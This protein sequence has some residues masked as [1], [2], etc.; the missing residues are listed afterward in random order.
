MAKRIVFVLLAILVLFVS[1]SEDMFGT[2]EPTDISLDKNLMEY[3][4]IS[5]V[6]GKNLQLIASVTTKDGNTTSDN[7][8]WMDMPTDTS[9]FKVVSTSKGILTFQ[10]YKS[11]TYVVTA[12]VKYRGQVTKTAQ[13]VI[14]IKD[15]LVCLD[16][17]ERNSSAFDSKTLYVGN[18]LSLAVD[19]TPSETSQTDVVW[20]VDNGDILTITEQDGG[21]AIASAKKAGTAVITAKSKDNS[22]IS[23]KVTIIV[24]ESGE[25]QKMPVRSVSLEMDGNEI[26][27]AKSAIINATVLDGNS[28][29]MST[30]KVE[31]SLTGEDATIAS[32]Q[33][34]SARSVKV[35]ANKGGNITVHAEYTND[36]T[37]VTADYPITI[38]GDISAIGVSS[39]YYNIAVNEEQEINVQYNSDIV[40]SRKGFTCNYDSNFINVV[41]SDKSSKMVIQA[42][43]EG[44]SKITLVSKC[45]SSL[46]AEI[47]V[48]AKTAVTEADRIHKVTLSA[49]QLNYYPVSGGFTEGTLSAYVYRRGD[50]GTNSVDST[51]NV[52]WSISDPS[53]AILTEGANNSVSVRPVK[54]GK[55]VITAKSADNEKVSASANITVNG[56]LVSLIAQTSTVNMSGEEEIDIPLIAYPEYAVYSAPKAQCSND[57]VSAS[58][59]KTDDVYSL[60]IKAKSLSGVTSVDVY[61]NGKVMETVMVNVHISEPVTIRTV[62]LSSSSFSLK[63]DSDPVYVEA[64]ALDKDGNEIETE[65][66][67]KGD[68]NAKSVSKIERVGTNGFYIYP[69]NAGYADW[70]FYS[71]SAKTEARLHL[72]V[73]GG[74]VTETIRLKAETDSVSIVKGNSYEVELNVLPFGA[75]LKENIIWT[76]E[77]QAVADVKGNGLNATVYAIGKGSTIIH[78]E[79]DVSGLTANITVN[80]VEKAQVEDTNI[81]YVEIAGSGSKTHLV[82][83]ALNKAITLNA[84]AYKAD[85]TKITAE[86]FIWTLSGSSATELNTSGSSYTVRTSDFGGYDNPA[87]ITATSVSNPNAKATFKVYVI[88]GST[89]VPETAPK[90][91]ISCA[92]ITLEVN[93]TKSV[94]YVVLPATYSENLTVQISNDNIEASV[95]QNAR[96]ITVK[97]LK[98]GLATVT[99]TNGEK[100]VAFNVNVVEK[101]EKIDTNISSLTL[102]R[103]YLSYDL[104]SKAPQTISATV[105]KNGIACDEKVIWTLSSPDMVS[106]TENGNSVLVMPSDKV[107]TVTI[108]AS[109]ASNPSVKASCLV[110]II[111]STTIKQALRYVMLS[112]SVVEL[113]KGQSVSLTAS[114]QPASVFAEADVTWSTSN[115]SIATVKDGEVKAVSAGQAVITVSAEG[116]T[117]GCLVIVKED[118]VVPETPKSITLS[119]SVLLLSQED[120]DKTFSITA[121]VQSSAGGTITD[122]SVIWS[123]EDPNG[124]VEYNTSYNTITLVPMSAG[125]ATITAKMDDIE[126]QA[127]VIVGEAYVD[128]SLSDIILSYDTLVLETGKTSDVRATTV[129]A[130]SEDNLVWE[131]SNTNVSITQKDN[132]NVVLKG[133][134]EGETILTVYSIENPSVKT[135]MNITVKKV[136]DPNEVTAIKLDKSM[137]IFDQA[138]KSSTYI[139]ATVYKGGKASE[140]KVSWNY[141]TNLSSVLKVE[142]IDN[143]A[144]LTKYSNSTKT[145][146]GYITAFAS[147]NTKFSAKVLVRVINSADQ[148]VKLTEA[149]LNSSAISLQEGDTYDFVVRTIP[150]DLKTNVSWIVSDTD[151]AT[152]DQT[153]KFTAKKS[154]YCKVRALV[155]YNDRTIET[156]CN[157]TVYAKPEEIVVPSSIRFTK[158]AVY[159]SQEKMDASETVV[160]TVFDSSYAEMKDAQ[161]IWTIADPTV[162]SIETNGNEV[163]ISPL[164]AGKTTVKAT[165]RNIS[166]TIT[167]VVG[168]KSEV[169]AD[170]VANIVF[171]SDNIIMEKGDSKTV[172]ASVVPAGINDNVSYMISAPSVVEIKANGDNTVTL[173]AKQAG[174]AILLATSVAEPSLKAFMAIKVLDSTENVVTAIKLDK[175]YITLS[176]DEKALTELKATVYVNDKATKNVKVSWSL[177]GLDDSQLLYTPSDTYASSVYLTKKAAGTGYIVATAGEVSARCYVEIVESSV[178]D[179]LKDII[180]SDTNLVLRR[181]Q[182]YTVKTTMVPDNIVTDIAWTT[183]DNTI[184]TV[185]S[186]G[187]ITGL[188]EGNAVITVHSYKYD[189]HK[190]VQVQVLADEIEA[191]KASFIRLSVQTV[192]LSQTDG[193]T[194]DVTATVIATDGQPISGATVTWAMDSEGVASMQVEGNTV[195][196]SAL[197]A[198]KTTLRAYYG[199]LGASASVYTGMVP[200][201]DVKSLDHIVL[202]PSVLTIQ[203]GGEGELNAYS[204]PAGLDIVPVWESE[205]TDI[206]AVKAGEG[207]VAYVTAV[208]EGN[209]TVT[210]KDRGTEKT[211]NAKIR[212]RDDISNVITGVTLDKSSIMLD[213]NDPDSSIIVNADVYVANTLNLDEPVVWAFASEDGNEGV[214]GFIENDAKARS[215]TI[216]PFAEGKG[217]L[218]AFAKND[219]EVYA[220]A[221]VRVINSETIAKTITELRMEVDSIAMKKGDVLKIKAIAT[222]EDLPADIRWT[223]EEGK[224]VVSV[225]IYGNV[226]AKEAGNAVVK[227]YIYGNS[228]LC[229]TVSIT[230]IDT[231]QTP[232]VYD[233]GSITIT[234][235]SA[236]LAQD[237]KLPTAFTATVYDRSGKAINEENVEWDT[238]GLGD[239]AEVTRTEGNTIYLMGKNAGR[240]TLTAKR[241]SQD[242]SVVSKTVDIYT[243]VASLDP[244]TE[245]KA[246]FIRLSVQTVELSQTDGKTKDVVATVYT[247]E[248]TPIAG[249]T[250]T[251]ALD[252]ENVASMV[253]N[254]NAVTLG[255]LNTGTTTLRAYYGTLSASASVYVGVV[256]G[257]DVKTLDHITV[258]PSVLTIQTGTDGELSA[259]S[260]P[261]GLDLNVNWQA[262]DTT[263][264]TVKANELVAAVTGVKQGKTTVTAKDVNTEKSSTA[265]VRV[266]DDISSVVTGVV[267]DKESLTIDL[268]SDLLQAVVKAMVYVANTYNASS[269]VE[270][271]FYNDTLTEK[272]DIVSLSALDGSSV[273]VKG[274]KVGSGYLRATAKNDSEVYAQAFVR[275]IDS[276]TIARTL[277]EIRLEADAI[278]MERGTT[279]KIN[280]IT[281]PSD[282]PADVRWEV[283]EGADIVSVDAYGNVTAKAKGTAIVKAYVYGNAELFATIA[284]TVVE[285]GSTALE[286]IAFDSSSPVYLVVG[287]EKQVKV[288]Y[289]PNDESVKGLV[290]TLKGDTG[291][292]SSSMNDAGITLKALA[293]TSENPL[294]TATSIAKNAE[295]KNLSTNLEVKVV[296]TKADLP[297]VTSLVL[298]KTAIVLNLADKADVVITATGYDY[299]GNE[300]KNAAISWALEENAGT[301]VTLTASTG[302]S[303]GINKGSKTG[304][305]KLV[306]TCGEVKATCSIEIVD[307]TAFS[308]ISL[309]SDSVYLTVGS[310]F[311][312][313]VYGTPA[314]L[315]K[316]ATVSKGSNADAVTVE[317]DSTNTVFT[318]TADKAGT[319][320]L[321]FI[322]EVDGKIYSADATVYVNDADALGVSRINLVPS[323]AY[324]QIGKTVDLEARLY[325]KK[326]REVFA[327]VDFSITDPSV[328]SITSEGARV[329]VEGLTEGSAIIYAKSGEAE[330]PAFISVGKTEKQIISDTSLTKI[331]PGMSQI[332]LKKGEV[333]KVNISTVPSDNTDVITGVSNQENVAAISVEDRIATITATGNG[334]AILT[335]TS[336]SVAETIDVK[337]VGE[338]TAAVIKLDQTS[339]VLTQE[340]GQSATVSAKVYSSDN[341]E[342][343]VQIANWTADDDSIVNITDLGNNTVKVE[344]RNSGSTYVWAHYGELKAGFRVAVSEKQSQATGPSSI[345]MATPSLT[346]KVGREETVSV[347]Y[348]PNGLSDSAK[349][350][351]WASS[352]SS[353]VTVEGLGTGETAKVRAISAGKATLTAS[354]V[355]SKDVVA[356]MTVT[357]LSS[358]STIDIYKIKLDK[359]SVR[360]DLSTDVV[361]NATLTKNGEEVDASDVQWSFESNNS[362]LDFVTSEA[363]AQSY[364][365]QTV[366]VRAKEKAGYA[367]ILATYGNASAKVQVEVADLAVV[368]DTGL[369]SV[370]ISD[371]TMLMEVG[372]KATFKAT[373]NPAVTGVKYVWTQTEK[374]GTAIAEAK[375]N[376]VNL[377]SQSGSSIT[378]SAVKTGTVILNL[379]AILENFP[380][381]KD[382]VTIQILEKGATSAVFN[383]SGVKMSSSSL[384]LA[385]GADSSYITATLID[386]AKQ[387]TEDAISKWTLLNEKGE[388]ILYWENGKYVYNENSYTE[389][390]E[391]KKAGFAELNDFS[392]IGADNRMLRVVPG[393]AGIY[394]VEAYGPEEGSKETP[395][396]VS[397]RTMLSVSGSISAVTFSSSYV[398]LIKGASTTIS[399]SKDPVTAQLETYQ[400]SAGE[401]LSLSE[402]TNDSVIVTGS[403]LGEADLVYTATDTNGKSVSCTMHITVHD[404]SWGTGGIKQVSFPSAFVTLGFPYV[405]QTY[406]AEAYYMDGTTASDAE[407]T[408]RK[409]VSINGVWTDVEDASNIVKDGKVIATFT[410][411]ENR[412]ITITPVEKGE[413][414]VIAELTNNGQNYSSEMYVSIGGNSNNLTASSSSV[415]LYT[416]GSASVSLS[417]DNPA[418]DSGFYAQILEEKTAD[419]YVIENGVIKATGEKMSEVLKIANANE[420]GIINATEL[421]LGSKILV[422]NKTSQT[423]LNA[424]KEKMELSDEDFIGL[425]ADYTSDSF[426]RILETF[427]RTASIR[428][429]T[430][431]GQSSTDIAVTIR[432]LPEGNS[433]PIS[434]KLSADK[435]DLQPPFT[436]EQNIKATLYDQ[437]GSE[438]KGTIEWYFYPVGASYTDMEGETLR[439]KLDTSQKNE[440]EEISA[441]FN[442]KTMYYTPK[443]AGL[444][445]LLVLCKQNPQLSYEATFNISGEVTGVSSSVGQN[446]SVAKNN[447]SEVSAVFS[448]VNALA[449]NVVFAIDESVGGGVAAK[450]LDPDVIYTN[451]FIRVSVG[452]DIA[453]VTGL[454]GT[455]GNDIQ[456][457]RILYGKETEDNTKLESAYRKGYF[458]KLIGREQFTVVDS[459]GQVVVD[460]LGNEITI[461]AYYTIVNISVTVTKAIYSFTTQSS[462]NIDPS[463]LENG[464][465]SFDFVSTAS[466]EDG[467][468][469]VSPFSRWDW[470]E[471]RIVGDDSGLIYASSVPVNAEGKSL[472]EVEKTTNGVKETVWGWYDDAGLFHEEANHDLF[473]NYKKEEYSYKENVTN[474]SWSPIILSGGMAYYVD[475]SYN[476]KQISGVTYSTLKAMPENDENSAS[477]FLVKRTAMGLATKSG[478]YSGAL[479]Q[480]NGGSTYFFKL[481]SEALGDETLRIQIRLKDSVK[482]GNPVYTNDVY[483]NE[484]SFTTYGFDREAVQIKE[485]N[486][487]LSIGGKIQNIYTGTVIRENHGSTVSETLTENIEQIKMFEGASVTLIPTYN[488][489]STHEK[490]IVWELQGVSQ[491]GGVVSQE[492]LD[493]WITHSELNASQL[494]ITAKAFGSVAENDHR[495]V[496]VIARSTADAS[497]YCRYEIDIQTMIKSLTFTSV[498]QVQTNK[499][500]TSGLYSSPIYKSVASDSNQATESIA[501]IYCYDTIDSSGGGGNMDAY[502][503]SYD[504]TPDYGFDLSVEVLDNSVSGSGQVIGTIDQTGIAQGAK[505]FRFIPTGRVYS[506]YDDNGI[507]KGGY[508]VA[509][510]DVKMRV[511]NTQINYSKEFTIHYAPSSFRL[512]KNIDSLNQETNTERELDSVF[513]YG[514]GQFEPESLTKETQ[515]ELDKSWDFLWEDSTKI[516]QGIECV[517]LYEP[518]GDKLGETID[519]TFAGVTILAKNDSLGNLQNKTVI[520]SYANPVSMAKYKDG[521]AINTQEG[522]IVDKIT[523]TW[524]LLKENGNTESTDIAC[525]EDEN[526]NNLGAFYTSDSLNVAKIRALES[527]KAYLQYTI[528]YC[529]TDGDGKIINTQKVT[530]AGNVVTEPQTVKIS[531]GVPVYVISSVDQELMRLVQSSL[532]SYAFLN[533]TNVSALIPERISRC[534]IDKWYALSSSNSITNS[535]GQIIAGAIYMGRAYAAFGKTPD[536]GLYVGQTLVYGLDNVGEKIK[537]TELQTDNRG[538]VI[539]LGSKEIKSIC[540]TLMYPASAFATSSISQKKYLEGASWGVKTYKDVNLADLSK[541]K[542]VT[543]LIIDETK[544]EEEGVTV[545]IT[546]ADLFS[547]NKGDFSNTGVTRIAITGKGATDTGL[548]VLKLANES[549]CETGYV[550]LSKIAFNGTITGKVK[551]FSATELASASVNVKDMAGDVKLSSSGD[552]NFSGEATSLTLAKDAFVVLDGCKIGTTIKGDFT[553]CLSVE[554]SQFT[555]PANTSII[556]PCASAVSLSGPLGT[557]KSNAIS[558]VSLTGNTNITAFTLAGCHI[559]NLDLTGC[560]SLYSSIQGAWNSWN[561][562]N[563]TVQN[564]DWTSVSI[565]NTYMSS[566]D[567]SKS[568]SLSRLN[569]NV[570]NKG[571]NFNTIRANSCALVIVNVYMNVNN[572]AT[573]A[574][575]YLGDN[576]LGVGY[577][578]KYTLKYG[579]VKD[580]DNTLTINGKNIT[581]GWPGSTGYIGSIN[582]DFTSE[583]VGLENLQ[584]DLSNNKICYSAGFSR[585]KENGTWCITIKVRT[586]GT[587]ANKY[588]VRYWTS[589][590]DDGDKNFAFEG[591]LIADSDTIK[592]IGRED[593]LNTNFSYTLKNIGKSSNTTITF[594]NWRDKDVK[595]IPIKA[596]RGPEI[597]VYPFGEDSL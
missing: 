368:Q 315:F 483:S 147:D 571:E 358:A 233:I 514:I 344:P 474:E 96:N 408:Y 228:S 379:E 244:I 418:Y 187:T 178:V 485:T 258:S 568:V 475:S 314:S 504:V 216:K 118:I 159:L 70:F 80:V 374:D 548:S 433:Y 103:S 367:Y 179:S 338:A 153:G 168:A 201:E 429:T 289:R 69:Q 425:D 340:E 214:I 322:T 154:G 162:A 213:I 49:N 43:K 134:T 501:D 574:G 208:K 157:V 341:A 31:F 438:T 75:E 90:F 98:A 415:V 542:W 22:S 317:S 239:I 376:Y 389:F 205:N 412:T 193:K 25:T 17:K 248:G 414:R 170:K 533:G 32:L 525:F 105:Y 329:T 576:K 236:I 468:S 191:A 551:A 581:L 206:A 95:N 209:T 200:G 116:K 590:P 121:T 566:L 61:V 77:N 370:I 241:T 518:E 300:V 559:N 59:V 467:S 537:K 387:E 9:A 383:Y 182:S 434:I 553:G 350:I 524:E 297:S 305:I 292:I 290:W 523:V 76:V 442:G 152:I 596:A 560:T 561:V 155:T 120:M 249:A 130:G 362:I 421:V 109:A 466:S 132:R 254:E 220:Q 546:I 28:N 446:L 234:P 252:N 431:D 141:A 115:A 38:T 310:S 495:I 247:T 572:S 316:G 484:N 272:S 175:N 288:N 245:G 339:V 579:I 578:M 72:E 215:I 57:N 284:I 595:G 268:N 313:T 41:E 84:S 280:A 395:V 356:S 477:N 404:I 347:L 230:V 296:A 455:T 577:K 55:A 202:E 223:V 126:A 139:T 6:R 320:S 538:V 382:Y 110:E 459:D 393:K 458:V 198:G 291:F 541:V 26:Q 304:T 114:G 94:D 113:Q 394:F 46:K 86:N 589:A 197:N 85:G 471:C 464:K 445:R 580:C 583:W 486:L 261:V 424:L 135:N 447:S 306:A 128:D 251:W 227:A 67:F 492:V 52:I 106:L 266:F 150:L 256:P 591:K 505:A 129:P 229:D 535:E 165:Y 11:G 246:S 257:E 441:Y 160:A 117:A 34:A 500:V 107:G 328:A 498:G 131:L 250:V 323:L 308:G 18:S 512:V 123:V 260:F 354:A 122:R 143:M 422:S 375:D 386:T 469:S 277:T 401:A 137:I 20:S 390:S 275:V 443:K 264:A 558:T 156:S 218:R 262:E 221:Y 89:V 509:Y 142:T 309:S 1:C 409:Q 497:I 587:Q 301:D 420:K 522:E 125:T 56:E 283:L 40:D 171:D 517:V 378:V 269:A 478:D 567:V 585:S 337:V 377:V 444:Y 100:S 515:D 346:L 23:D 65:I 286:S 335:L 318:I 482:Y 388:E 287:D 271:E 488:P 510:G 403:Y 457:M 64:K 312:I 176:M 511:Y 71:D 174:T 302:K 282:L 461:N 487:A 470:L 573:S 145:A 363:L 195:T 345:S 186:N 543:G 112:E 224:D 79:S 334:S 58:I 15:A 92:S 539:S 526:G 593:C 212:V 235:S 507:G 279:R 185:N 432:R 330:S 536:A 48:N 353:V 138:N 489:T 357:V 594:K 336:G 91:L 53:V 203:T 582:R 402:Q 188:S 556:L 450:L 267:L 530:D 397:A 385:Q 140:G 68:E 380:S 396:R 189:I 62:Q 158:N 372:E 111:D 54:P 240:G 7:I 93:A 184:A 136:V 491:S 419:G 19:Y 451:A 29:V 417:L 222:P 273:S 242:G 519:L 293:V 481:N 167:V 144:F 563:L 78:A 319:A 476:K 529:L 448:P 108:T 161:V 324:V 437:L 47:T 502:F 73:G 326:G 231:E 217:Y 550:T 151:V 194:K 569:V 597:Y 531:G 552:F 226:T 285:P 439:W 534:Q 219:N 127:K 87:I 516:I 428:V 436:A 276:K 557:S 163:K 463:L 294:I 544:L 83:S 452:G 479:S 555:E 166:N 513:T 406:K 435:V 430:L 190:E 274:V 24:Q 456:R 5:D 148:S 102:N 37:T 21:K 413:F 348:Q 146:M 423:E 472:Y 360:M 343:A 410:E 371:K 503:I 27:I 506:E 351:K 540:E 520:Q 210:V 3:E 13:C 265:T 407:I 42:V 311:K 496:Y 449:R 298:D 180:L 528:E 549:I 295:G 342:I 532:V 392:V 299:E 33:N 359:S 36:G 592:T 50:D 278:T 63:Q 398:H 570:T 183:S 547:S 586:A 427:P 207:S 465:I 373:V 527:G 584:I 35:Y 426:K 361:I 211:A 44:T 39:S 494:M 303:V 355:S 99:L 225:D 232:S 270:W 259:S 490:G 82:E 384:S 30:G 97:G 10:I 400:W 173:T 255:A 366:T 281:T 204:Y 369:R 66:L 565:E 119:E 399:V 352:D 199:N 588:V 364:K 101:A 545:G 237:A 554:N 462:R 508:T 124:V 196:L 349:G 453:T 8:V 307:Y 411:G 493:S 192:E 321:R 480:D 460:E 333:V 575:L 60:H 172:K 74:A 81:A 391:L 133:V 521:I 440:K 12:G 499:N 562:K 365:G 327:A 149:M 243:G 4:T 405:A 45:D 104:A 51:K 325:D 331:I 381:V 332:T 473:Y 177:E 564:A 14:T 16:I 238:V 263:V 88:A 454:T 181:N 416:G 2:K 169:L 253:V 164:S